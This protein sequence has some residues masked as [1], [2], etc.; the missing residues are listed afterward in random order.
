MMLF[1]PELRL[2]ENTLVLSSVNMQVVC[3][4]LSNFKIFIIQI[5]WQIEMNVVYFRNVDKFRKTNKY[6][7]N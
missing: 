3:D 4:I 2:N 6:F 5:F 1:H 7:Q